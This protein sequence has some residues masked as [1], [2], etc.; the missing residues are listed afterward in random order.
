MTIDE[1]NT[2][3]KQQLKIN[4]YIEKYDDIS[5]S[6][7]ANIDNIVSDTEIDDEY[8]SIEF[9]EEDFLRWTKLVIIGWINTCKIAVIYLKIILVGRNKPWIKI[10]CNLSMNLNYLMN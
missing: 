1:L 5:Y 10:Y 3:Q 4:Y 9:V 8:G 2:E 6:D 7:M